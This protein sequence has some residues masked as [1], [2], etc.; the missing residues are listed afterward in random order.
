MSD[1]CAAPRRKAQSGTSRFRA[2]NSADARTFCIRVP[3]AR[4]RGNTDCVF[5]ICSRFDVVSAIPGHALGQA[6]DV[7]QEWDESGLEAFFQAVETWLGFYDEVHEFVAGKQ[8]DVKLIRLSAQARSELGASKVV[9]SCPALDRL[10]R[11]YICSVRQ[12]PAVHTPPFPLFCVKNLPGISE[13]GCSA[14]LR[15]TR[16]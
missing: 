16:V 6:V 9:W 7:G 4:R 8:E 14:I 13:R 11:Q 5:P 15:I 2:Y 3:H 10:E 12:P 1:S